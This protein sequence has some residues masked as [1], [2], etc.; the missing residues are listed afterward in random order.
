MHS[1]SPLVAETETLLN[2]LSVERVA[3]H[4]HFDQSIDT[5]L[6]C[7][8]NIAS[9]F[10]LLIYDCVRRFLHTI[11]QRLAVRCSL[12]TE[13]NWSQRAHTELAYHSTRDFDCA[14]DV[15]RGT[16]RHSVKQDLLGGATT[17]EQCDPILK[18][19]TFFHE[20]VSFGK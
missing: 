13:V 16:S 20:P 8:H 9:S 10:Q 1:S 5:L 11:Q 17:Q 2:L 7:C 15:V 14:L 4:Q 6:S 12:C 3:L 19:L 18:V